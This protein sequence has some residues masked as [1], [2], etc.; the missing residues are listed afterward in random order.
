[1]PVLAGFGVASSLRDGF[2]RKKG[3]EDV[4]KMVPLHGQK[5]V[6]VALILV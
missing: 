6:I 3:E 5:S 1:M 2:S 4:Q